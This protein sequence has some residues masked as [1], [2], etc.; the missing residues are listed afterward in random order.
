[1]LACDLLQFK[2]MRCTFAGICWD[3]QQLQPQQ[4]GQQPLASCP[5]QPFL[6]FPLL[7]SPPPHPSGAGPCCLTK[8]Q[9]M[10]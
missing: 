10:T 7:P 4:P 2:V 3:H 8:D 9:V 5:L 1:M 6:L